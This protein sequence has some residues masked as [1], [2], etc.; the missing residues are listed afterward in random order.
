MYKFN[1]MQSIYII[2]LLLISTYDTNLITQ[3]LNLYYDDI[4]IN[5]K[6]FKST[7]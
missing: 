2:S 7:C 4:D 3:V 1:I 6:S 5:T